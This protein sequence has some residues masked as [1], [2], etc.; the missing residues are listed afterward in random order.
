MPR[1][2]SKI[3]DYKDEIIERWS[4]GEPID[5]I[6]RYLLTHIEVTQRTLERRLQQWDLFRRSRTIITPEIVSLIR[7]LVFDY[8]YKD[9]S[10]LRD[11]RREGIELS[12]RGLQL[13]RLKHGIKRRFRTDEER[14]EIMNQAQ[15]FLEE[16]DRYSS[17]AR[18][19]GRS[20]LYRLLRTRAGILVGRNRIYQIYK[21]LYPA[22][23]QRRREAGW[24]HR[25]E[26]QVPGPNW[27]WSLDGYAKL[28]D[29]GF[30]IYA[31][32]DAYSRLIIWIYVGRSAT[33][34]IS[35]LKQFLRTVM[36]GEIRPC[37]TRADH[38]VET[39]LWVGAQAT[40]AD[41]A[42][43]EIA[44]DDSDGNP[45]IHH[46]GS[47]ITSV[48]M[49]GPSTRNIKIESWWRRF[50]EGS[51]DRW[52]GFKNTLIHNALFIPGDPIDLIAVYAIYGPMIK[53]EFAEFVEIWNSHSIRKQRNR[54]HVRPGIPYDLYN[55]DEVPNWGIPVEEGSP[56]YE[57]AQV[58]YQPLEDIEIDEFM[59]PETTEWC[60]RQL[61]ALG[62][63]G[64]LHTEEDHINPHI[65]T[66]VQ[67]REIVRGHVISGQEPHLQLIEAPT[68]GTER[69]IGLLNLLRDNHPLFANDN[70]RGDEPPQGVVNAVQQMQDGDNDLDD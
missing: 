66:Y 17:S 61:E 50:R 64:I 25:T 51:T 9:A 47:R 3:D 7:Y 63:D 21:E 18:R 42:R 11:L 14:N 2:P 52:I 31:C 4:I 15:A 8:G 69:Y 6:H 56:A 34:A 26:F 28:A 57:A 48:H 22:E 30:Q 62:F 67:L 54:P 16:R 38:G 5:S 45:Q 39:P 35:T 53:D 68:G 32:I 59:T 55:T 29:F 19:Y 13:V 27:L 36:Q 33:T 49:Y 40:L 44:Y 43:T 1:P 10:V 46:Q 37:F 65:R 12:P 24:S 20:Y 60:E 41:A 23:V 70:L 58:M